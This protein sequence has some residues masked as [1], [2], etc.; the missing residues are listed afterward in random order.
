MEV[1]SQAIYDDFTGFTFNGQ[2]SSQFGLLR[3]SNGDRYED[4][5]VPSLGDESANIPGGIGK[6]YLGESIKEGKFELS[7]AYDN[8]SEKDKRKIKLWLH[9]D[10]KLHELIF[11]EKPYIKYWVKCSK[12]I[13]TSELCFN[14]KGQRVYKGDFKIEFTAYMPYGIAVS[15]N[16]DDFSNEE[17][18]YY[19]ENY[20][21]WK[22]SCG[23][24]SLNEK[25]INVFSNNKAKIYNGG[26]V[27]TGFCLEFDL[28]A[29]SIEFQYSGESNGMI[30]GYILYT[31]SLTEKN[32][33][34][35]LFVYINGNQ[36]RIVKYSEEDK[37]F[38][39]VKLE[40]TNIDGKIIE[41]SG[42]SKFE[43]AN[44]GMVYDIYQSGAEIKCYNY[45]SEISNWDS[46]L[47]FNKEN[48]YYAVSA[49]IGHLI[50]I[51]NITEK[52]CTLYFPNG[53]IPDDN[54]LKLLRFPSNKNSNEIF[55]IEESDN[56][57]FVF[58][59][60]AAAVTSPNT[61]NEAQKALFYGGKIKI[62]TNKQIIDYK[63]YEASIDAW[64]EWNG[65]MGILTE[66]S[67]FKI[68]SDIY[69]YL[70]DSNNILFKT[71]SI[72]SNNMDIE[73]PQISY[74]YLY[75]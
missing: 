1:Y 53:E 63:K 14:E 52:G 64:S 74:E 69:A 3:V 54:F 58:A 50:F 7:I 23:L 56:E 43:E 42:I 75:I 32:F 62:D 15:K 11:D 2:H 9:P 51:N 31:D 17:S 19:R 73:N 39:L 37:A 49:N 46:I 12:D 38:P 59:V 5:L 41:Q 29:K 66:G 65:I 67:L 34:N 35:E 57:K 68:P 33:N 13:T 8:I 25:N 30:E 70:I 36:D 22:E 18:D 47:G 48:R 27:E 21:E 45:I 4:N 26:D 28:T 60:E 40:N 72:A 20:N 16:L 6:Y 61:W 71:F 10:D 55:Q 24:I 44:S